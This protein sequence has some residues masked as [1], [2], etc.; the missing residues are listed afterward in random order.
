MPFW[1]NKQNN[2]NAKRNLQ[3][4]HLGMTAKS[5]SN[6]KLL[7]LRIMIKND[8]KKRHRKK[9]QDHS[10]LRETIA[11]ILEDLFSKCAELAKKQQ[12]TPFL[13]DFIM[14]FGT[15]LTFPL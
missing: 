3:E 15:T 7:L 1:T 11:S 2:P 6:L 12:K 4:F 10:T 13:L 14:I 9:H 8:V 5:G